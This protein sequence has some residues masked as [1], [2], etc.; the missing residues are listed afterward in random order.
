MDKVSEFFNK[1]MKSWLQDNDIKIYSAHSEGK[2]VVAKRLIRTLKNKIY[3]Y[4]TSISKNVHTDK[5]NYTNDKYSNI[6]HTKVKMKFTNVDSSTYID[7][8]VKNNDKDLK[9]KVDDGLRITN[10]K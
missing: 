10:N 5:L 8:E 4:L 9:F 3:K 2:F 6:Y 1:S 7:F